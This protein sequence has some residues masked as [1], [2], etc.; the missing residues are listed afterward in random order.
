MHLL[1]EDLPLQNTLRIY[2]NVELQLPVSPL[3]LARVLVE[4]TTIQEA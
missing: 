3:Q 1:D 4:L 2:R